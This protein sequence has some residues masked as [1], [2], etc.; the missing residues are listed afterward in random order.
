MSEVFVAE[1]I[2]DGR[3]TIPLPVR[4]LLGLKAGDLVKVKIISKAGVKEVPAV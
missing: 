4:E 1:I 2:S 3:L